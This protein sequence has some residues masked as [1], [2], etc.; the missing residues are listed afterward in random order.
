MEDFGYLKYDQQGKASV[1]IKKSLIIGAVLLS[2]LCFFYVAV[3]AYYFIYH[4]ENSDIKI[5]RSPKIPVKVKEDGSGDIVIRD[6]DKAVYNNIIGGKEE[7]LQS[8]DIKIVTA[9]ANPISLDNVIEDGVI[10]N[11]RIIKSAQEQKVV[12]YDLE[13]NKDQIASSDVQEQSSALPDLSLSRVQIAALSSEK[14]A[15]EYWFKLKKQYPKLF[16]DQ[17]KPFIQKVDLG[18]RGVFYRLQIGNFSNQVQAEDF[19]IEFINKAGKSKADCIIV[20]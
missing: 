3:S 8:K 4:E 19:C 11:S 2:I 12:T 14:S 16:T 10:N 6:L 5:V 18:R 7:S 13:S 15:N 17:L 20:E 1:I 9:P